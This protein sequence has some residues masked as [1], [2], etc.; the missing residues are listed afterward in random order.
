MLRNRRLARSVTALL[1]GAFVAQAAVS[2]AHAD[3]RTIN[4]APTA[5]GS[6]PSVAYIKT[7][8]TAGGKNYTSNCTSTVVAPHWVVTAAHCTY[9][10]PEPLTASQMTVITG[11]PN[12][13]TNTGVSH[14]VAEIVRHSGYRPGGLSYDIALLRLATATSAPPMEV[15]LQ[16]RVSTYQHL[17]NVPNVAGW[18]WTIPGDDTSSSDVLRETFVP[19][20][21]G[22]ACSAE[23]AH[24]APFDPSIMVC[25]GTGQTGATTT[26]HGDSG[27][28]LVIHNSRRQPVLWGVTNW[29]QPDCNGGI[30][31]FARVA[32][33]TS[34]L[35][36]AV[37]ELA[38]GAGD[39]VVPVAR[40]AGTAPAVPVPAAMPA[41][42]PTASASRDA[43]APRLSGVRMPATVF[44]RGGRPVRAL[45]LKL[46]C[47]ERATV[48]VYLLRR[49]GSKF[50][51]ARRYF[52][53]NVRKG[54]SRITLPRGLWRLAP[55]SYRV[56]IRVTDAAGNTRAYSAAIRARSI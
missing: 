2:P 36:R 15:A 56:Q 18:G 49:Q 13:N 47:S 10:E 25:A 1:A 23:L 51:Q 31:A 4:G 19:L 26:C 37:P 50:A 17:P 52:V 21:S 43:V 40:P 12:L 44:V 39:A 6:W 7:A 30:S 20:Q 38:G 55:G 8:F 24:V 16:S 33:F 27:G 45:T 11:R 32:A 22:N 53:A 41:A 46:R 3:T 5:D 42:A 28:P 9:G 29:G 35:A 14:A 48:R 54:A 34:F